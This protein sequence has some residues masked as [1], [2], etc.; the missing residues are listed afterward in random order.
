MRV[1]VSGM[2]AGFGRRLKVRISA[3]F[4]SL[5]RRASAAVAAVRPHH[6]GGRPSATVSPGESTQRSMERPC[7]GRA[8]SAPSDRTRWGTSVPSGAV[9]LLQGRQ[10]IERRRLR[11]GAAAVSCRVTRSGTDSASRST[12]PPLRLVSALAAR[13][14][15]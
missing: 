5:V 12:R 9:S 13:A 8:A 7:T 3:M 11:R 4:Q 10:V 1:R 14:S 2:R 15:A 6:R